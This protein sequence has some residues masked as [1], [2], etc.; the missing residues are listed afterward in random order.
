MVMRK[1]KTLELRGGRVFQKAPA[2]DASSE[3]QTLS[4]CRIRRATLS[5]SVKIQNQ[6][7]PQARET[8]R[9]FSHT[10]RDARGVAASE[11]SARDGAWCG[12]RR[13]RRAAEH[14]HARADVDAAIKVFDV[15]IGQ[16]D[17]ARRNE[18]ADG[19]GLIGAVNA[20][21]GVA[22]IERARA[23]RVAFA[24]GH[25]ARQI[26][27]P[28]DHFLRRMPVRPFAHVFDTFDTGPSESFASDAH[29]VAQRLAAAEH[30]IK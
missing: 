10:K 16:P 21:H 1:L 22:E 11:S 7:L 2:A 25:E 3:S 26:R 28:L 12:S 23:E 30:Q 5:E 18:V 20:I 8:P 13:G 9:W 27:L 4:V 14:D 6:K 24:A 19:R 29:A 17:A 15:R